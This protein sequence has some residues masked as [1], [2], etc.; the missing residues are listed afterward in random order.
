MPHRFWWGPSEVRHT[1]NKK[2]RTVNSNVWPDQWNP[3][4][5]VLLGGGLSST[6]QRCMANVRTAKCTSP[7]KK[8]VRLQFAQDPLGR[9]VK[10]NQLGKSWQRTDTKQTYLKQTARK[11][12]K[13]KE[14]VWVPLVIWKPS[15]MTTW[16]FVIVRLSM[17]RY[18]WT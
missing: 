10:A 18:V 17:P 5:F 8:V 2:G 1:K 3:G 12:R 11:K 16:Y 7:I 9:H 13:E 4:T 6:R 14:R 15:G